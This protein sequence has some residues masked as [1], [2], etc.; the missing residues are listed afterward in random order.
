MKLPRMGVAA[1]SGRS[2]V[3]FSIHSSGFKSLASSEGARTRVGGG[4]RVFTHED[5]HVPRPL[6]Q[7]KFRWIPLQSDER[8]PWESLVRLKSNPPALGLR[9]RPGISPGLRVVRTACCPVRLATRGRSGHGVGQSLSGPLAAPP[10][11]QAG[12]P[13]HPRKPPISRR[14]GKHFCK[15]PRVGSQSQAGWSEVPGGPIWGANATTVEQMSKRLFGSW[16][17]HDRRNATIEATTLGYDWTA[18]STSRWGVGNQVS[19]GPGVT[20]R[21][22]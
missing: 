1:C 19:V 4:E 13:G 18:S 17:D 6:G 20:T 15:S 10:P 21:S 3:Q 8:D 22:I 11:G 14:I 7:S 5:R 9:N 16:Q 2:L 12:C